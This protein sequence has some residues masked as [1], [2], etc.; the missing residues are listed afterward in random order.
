MNNASVLV[1]GANG[2]IGQPLCSY[3]LSKGYSV[4]AALRSKD[5]P[6]PKEC[7]PVVVGELNEHTQWKG[8]LSGITTV[9][10]LAGRAHV[11][12]ELSSDALSLYRQTNTAG[13]KQ[14][15]RMAV[16][17]G[18]RRFIFISSVKVNGEYT[19]QAPFTEKDP[20][21]PC[22]PYAVSK[23]EAECAL[24]ELTQENIMELVI[25]RLPLVYG[26]GVKA[27]FLRLISLVDKGVPLPLKNI[28]NKRSLIALDNVIDIISHCIDHQNA[29]NETFLLSDGHDLSTAELVELIARALKKPGRLFPFPAGLLRFLG[30]LINKN[31]EM[32]RLV[33]SLVVD[34]EKIQNMLSWSPVITVEAAV[35]KTVDW[36][37]ETLRKRK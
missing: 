10:H 5:T 3:L 21:H 33:G 34:S 15:A 19:L 4:R 16:E 32:Q 12:K 18:V 24:R 1:T 31:E 6:L 37:L 29:A 30:R 22:D 11:M 14:L 17:N 27:N 23:W 9:I 20:P 25:L 36:Y 13:T 35:Q 26:P 8:A 7:V 28:N 2:F